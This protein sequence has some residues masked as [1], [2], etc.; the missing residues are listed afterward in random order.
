MI[1]EK[2][3]VIDYSGNRQVIDYSGNSQVIDYSGNSQVI[4]YSG[5]SQVIDYS[6]NRKCCPG[7]SIN[8]QLTSSQVILVSVICK[9]NFG[10]VSTPVF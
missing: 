6:G 5:N 8:T 10:E 4:D 2:S 1:F 7:S 3:Q 9:I